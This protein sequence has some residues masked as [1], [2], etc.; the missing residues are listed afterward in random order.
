MIL[1]CG[2]LVEP[3]KATST[4]LATERSFHFIHLSAKQFIASLSTSDVDVPRNLSALSLK[5]DEAE[6]C[7]AAT[8][9]Q[10]LTYHLPAQPL[11]GRSSEGIGMVELKKSFPFAAYASLYWIQHLALVSSALAADKASRTN[12]GHDLQ[13]FSNALKRFLSHPSVVMA[14][15]E[16][17]YTSIGSDTLSEPLISCYSELGTWGTQMLRHNINPSDLFH[18]CLEFSHDLALLNKD[19]GPALY[20]NPRLIWGEVTAFVQSKFWA[21]TNSTSLKFLDGTSTPKLKSGTQSLCIISGTS[22]REDLMGV[23]VIW[24]SR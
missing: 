14:W 21:K 22:S 12:L 3:D 18:D 5:R 17:A 6:V 10:Y 20:A 9:L 4:A 19:M 2:G 13:R 8:C 16:A 23:L 15:I 24:P 7:L 11:S 1:T